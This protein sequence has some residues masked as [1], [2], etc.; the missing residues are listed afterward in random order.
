MRCEARVRIALLLASLL[1]SILACDLPNLSAS[2]DEVD[3]AATMTK[4]ALETEV[5]FAKETAQPGED[6]SIELPPSPRAYEVRVSVNEETRCFSGPG[7]NYEDLGLLKA[8]DSTEVVARSDDGMFF[9]IQF[10]HA[11]PDNCWIWGQNAQV[12]GE[13]RELPVFTPPPTSEQSTEPGLILQ[14]HVRMEDGSGVAGVTICRSFAS[15]AGEPVATTDAEGYYQSEYT[16]IP[17]DEMVTV[18]A[19][20]VDYVFD[21]EEYFWRH[22][23]GYREETLD[24][25]AAISVAADTMPD[26]R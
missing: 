13:L 3:P 8:G 5:A 17:G 9:Y 23:Y 10:P 12:D 25:T 20:H 24:F 14:G 18:W 16:Y 19:F 22:Y 21:P 11:P 26:C 4:Q 2:D 1:I 7:D 6:E 15:Y